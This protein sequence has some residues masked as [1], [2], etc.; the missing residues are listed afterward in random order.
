MNIVQQIQCKKEFALWLEGKGLPTKKY[1]VYKERV[2]RIFESLWKRRNK[3][4]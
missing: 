3:I 4:K 1:P 2:Y